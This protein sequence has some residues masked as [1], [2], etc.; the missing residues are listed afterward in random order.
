MYSQFKISE[1]IIKKLEGNISP[2]EQ[3]ILDDWKYLNLAN[4]NLYNK[5][6]Q[7]IENNLSL[8]EEKLKHVDK[9]KSWDN[10][11][12]KIQKNKRKKLLSKTLAYAASLIFFISSASFLY[13]KND[14]P[15]KY[16][17]KNI[18][19]PGQHQALLVMSKG[20]K[21]RLNSNIKLK[22]NGINISNNT[23]QLTYTKSKQ[24]KNTFKLEYNTIIVPKGGEYKLVLSDGTKIWMNS[25]SKLKYPVAFGHKQ[26][27]VFLEGEA[28]FDVAKDS[29]SPFI[30]SVNNFDVKVLGTSFNVSA[31]N[32]DETI[33][34][35]LV[36]GKVNIK[37]KI[38]KNTSLL[39]PNDQFIFNKANGENKKI[40]VNT[41]LYT[42][43]KDGRFVFEQER[44]DE[45]M[46]RLSRWYDIEVFFLG[47]EKKSLTFTGDI[48]RY[49][50][51]VEI[52]ELIELTNKVRFTIKDKSV[53]V[54]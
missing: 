30:V 5:L 18:I 21:L 2:S 14:V 38:W 39:L 19:V 53:M 31:Y 17:A 4:L 24:T 12:R 7:N 52:L 29:L 10:L 44:L 49:E 16:V 36:E 3:N 33:K 51:I 15:T 8:S 23:K 26:R 35:T 9:S 45:I 34:T 11:N 20:E 48:T 47:E 22:E 43:W 54:E 41:N 13:E 1:L 42:S 46:L 28:F 37:D 6:L 40:K 32:R 27:R 25:H 50:S